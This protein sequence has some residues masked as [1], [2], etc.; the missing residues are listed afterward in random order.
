[1][2][3]CADRRRKTAMRV[4]VSSMASYPFRAEQGHAAVGEKSG[5]GV[6]IGCIIAAPGFRST[7][8]PRRGVIMHLRTVAV[9][10]ALMVG[11]SQGQEIRGTISGT[12]TDPQGAQVVDASVVVTNTDTNVSATLTT[13]S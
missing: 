2:T 9:F 10:F 12:V 13:N 4:I 11:L 8:L 5:C 3:G 1:S 6:A 7:P